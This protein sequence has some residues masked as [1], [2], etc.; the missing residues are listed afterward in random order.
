M[1][2]LTVRVSDVILRAP[3]PE[4]REALV[5]EIEA[6]IEKQQLFIERTFDDVVEAMEAALKEA[7]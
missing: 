7:P 2:D 3:G 6:T 4:E 1:S 5:R